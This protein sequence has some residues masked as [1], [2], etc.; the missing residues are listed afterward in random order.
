MAS[1]FSLYFTA[2]ITVLNE[3][4]SIACLLTSVVD[5][6]LKNTYLSNRW[7]STRVS[8]DIHSTERG[9]QS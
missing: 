7:L 5:E 4:V 2:P 1:P 3:W 8:G 9:P 6:F